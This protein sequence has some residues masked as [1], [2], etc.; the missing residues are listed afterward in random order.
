[1]CGGQTSSRAGVG[2]G[3]ARGGEGDELGG[4]CWSDGIGDASDTRCEQFDNTVTTGKRSAACKNF[5]DEEHEADDA[6]NADGASGT[7]GRRRTEQ[8]SVSLMDV[9]VGTGVKRR[10]VAIDEGA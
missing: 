7:D 2:V 1:M 5:P 4:G 10:R 9:E 8:S 3:W 6:A